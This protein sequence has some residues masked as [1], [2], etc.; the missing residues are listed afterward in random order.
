MKAIYFE[1][2]GSSDVLQY[3]DINTPA[4][5]DDKQVLVRIKATGVNPIDCKIR[6]A[7]DRFPVTFPVIP[8]CDAAGIVETVGKGVQTIKPGDEV[9]FSQPGFNQRQ[10]TYAELV[11]VDASLLAKKPHT[12]SF[13]QAAAAPLVLITAW[14]ALHDRA[15]IS[16]GQTILIHAGAGGVGHVAI[17][18]AKLAGAKVITT[19]SNVEKSVLAKGLGAD[20]TILYK[21]HNVVDEVMNWT[22][23]EGVDIAFDTVGPS[24]LQS[25]FNSVKN[26]GDVVTILQPAADTNWSDARIRNIRFSFELM[27]TPVIL[28]IDSAKQHQSEILKRCATLIDDGK[29]KI[30]VART[31]DLAEAAAAQDFLE[32]QHP[33]GKVVLN[34]GQ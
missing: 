16:S 30:E 28:E 26:C 7:P 11:L 10:G 8:G 34:I 6:T 5:C 29:L 20:E 33:A 2:S 24:V 32:Q 25:C 31:F 21:S 9:Y 1:K 22:Y 17:Q 15:R 13:A 4:Q 3:G 18:L 23:G 14:E 12:L 27:L 19:V